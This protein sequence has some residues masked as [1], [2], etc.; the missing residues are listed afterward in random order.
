M[1]IKKFTQA[2]LALA[3]GLSLGACADEDANQENVSKQAVATNVASEQLAE[4]EDVE[5]T[6]EADTNEEVEST[7]IEVS[8]D[9][10]KEENQV[11]EVDQ[12]SETTDSQMSDGSYTATLITEANGERSPEAGYATTYNIELVDGK[13]LVSGSLDYQS[14]PDDYENIEEL[15]NDKYEFVI[16]DNTVFQTVGGLAEPENYDAQGFVDLYTEVKDSGLGLYIEVVNGIVK[17]AS[18]S[19]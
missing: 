18:Y 2:F 8:K 12:I 1:K 14:N 16:D 19:S 11:E 10:T 15:A 17:T 13:L 3:I 6:K 7:T 5:D 9:N 4:N